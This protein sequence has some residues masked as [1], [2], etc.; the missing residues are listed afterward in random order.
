M[1]QTT[2]LWVQRLQ[3]TAA[4][5]VDG[6]GA[7]TGR[8]WERPI[9]RAVEEDNYVPLKVFGMVAGA[10]AAFVVYLIFIT[11]KDLP[12]LPVSVILSLGVGGLMGWSFAST[13]Y[14]ALLFLWRTA[15]SILVI[16][17]PLVLVILLLRF[18]VGVLGFLF[19]PI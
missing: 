6:V 11:Q 16:M 8:I 2:P 12:N 9:E 15:L 19:T 17:G 3:R 7:I 4:A 18:L 14:A 10:I 13:I 1:T 5:Y